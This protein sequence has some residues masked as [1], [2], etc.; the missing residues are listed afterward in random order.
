MTIE[1][2]IKN[3][4]DQFAD[5]FNRGDL[6]VIVALHADDALL[7]SPDSPAE[8]GSEAVRLGF[9]ELLDAGWKNLSFTSVEL[10]SGGDIAYHVGKFAA[11]APTS[12]G[13]SN[14]VTGNYVDIYKLHEDGAL[15]IQV[16]SFNF[17]EP[18][19]D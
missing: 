6:A 14:R 2:Q 4:D 10:G 5:A 9:K 8:R 11:D 17:N 13:G 15:K 1:Q 18:L 16:T 3:T 12:S 19:P 7:L